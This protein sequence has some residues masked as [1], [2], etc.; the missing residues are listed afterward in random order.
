MV[1][2]QDKFK[3]IC[4]APLV[5]VT[6]FDLD[7]QHPG[8]EFLRYWRGLNGGQTPD[9]ASFRPQEIAPLLKWLMMFRRE[10]RGSDDLYFLYLQGN[11]AAELTDGLQQGTYLH[12]FTEEQCFDTRRGVLRQVLETGQ[13]GFAN[14]VVGEK[15]ADF[16]INI[17]VG[18]FP[19]ENKDGQ[20]EVVMV[21]A[22]ETP[23]L[24]LFL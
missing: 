7:T 10:L 21:P 6:E 4:N 23:E 11:S 3:S 2:W 15:S 5:G 12:D 13:P 1:G 16:T 19:F 8:L 14:I 18:A 24:R 9:R 22:P 17:N 20:P